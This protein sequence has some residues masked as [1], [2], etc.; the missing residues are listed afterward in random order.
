MSGSGYFNKIARVNLT[1]G[2]IKYDTFDDD[3]YKVFL[4]GSG[5]G[6]KILYDEVPKEVDPLHPNNKIIFATGPFQGTKIPGS[7]KWSLI[8]KSPLTYTLGD[9]AAGAKFGP[10][11]K[12]CGIDALIVEGK[13]KSPVYLW[14]E[15]D[16]L[17]IRNASGIW[18]LDSFDTIDAIKNETDKKASVAAIGPSG[19][20]KVRFA[21]VVVDKHS[22]AGRTGNGA[23]MGSKNL[24]A[25]SVLGGKKLEVHNEELLKE[26]QKDIIKKMAKNERGKDLRKWGTVGG[27]ETFNALDNTPK[28]YW[29][30][31]CWTEEG[32]P[33]GT[34]NYNETLN[35]KPKACLYCPLACH[36]HISITEPYV[37]DGPGPEY[38]TLA[39]LGANCLVND[40]KA[41]AKANDICNK[42][43][44]DTIST[45]SVIGFSMQAYEN[46]WIPA[47]QLGDMKIE[48]GDS[49]AVIRLVEMI[50]NR[51][52]IGDLLA[53]GTLN[54]AKKF[55]KED[56]V[57]HVRGL[58]LPGH[59]PRLCYSL[60]V[61]YATG[62][63]GA[64]HYRGCPEE[65]EI[66]GFI[67]PEFDVGKKPKFFV[68]EDKTKL[69]IVHQD[70]GAFLG[71]AVLCAFVFVEGEASITQYLDALNATTGWGWSIKD[72]A[73]CGERIYNF[74]R[75]LNIRDGKGPE[76]DIL[77][78]KL[79]VPSKE[80]PRKGRVPPF[81]EMLKE[82]Y[83]LRG[84]D[85]KG[86]PPK[87]KLESIGLKGGFS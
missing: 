79:M 69:A 66:G 40:A 56:Y 67:L 42:L 20:S 19:E 7:A 9:S 32:E 55:G 29:D 48:W 64:C 31:C 53:E 46:G 22:Y 49:E 58:D 21:C 38:E 5:L 25:V 1:D 36:R 8:S 63:R 10:N 44:I 61:N 28:K 3:F 2:K 4:G 60:A 74:Q 34:P 17:E 51:K 83:A 18:G 62:T 85:E 23:V 80:G 68:V 14:I 81:E 73:T 54:V 76:Y 75:L 6:A 50:G 59:D 12:G 11:I 57:V 84:W 78:K 71:S 45:G 33:L 41:I 82:C 15:E 52:G 87:A 26:I 86:Y 37:I 13:S 72:L 27:F 30:G 70:F 43:G 39:L 16:N 24:K 35:V 65:T 77:P 47:A